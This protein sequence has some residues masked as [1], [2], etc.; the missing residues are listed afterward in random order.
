[1]ETDFLLLSRQQQLHL[2]LG[3]PIT[4]ADAR[5]VER[6]EAAVGTTWITQARRL[7]DVFLRSDECFVPT[8]QTGTLTLEAVG[9]ASKVCITHHARHSPSGLLQ[10]LRLS[11][12]AALHKLARAVE[13]KP[14]LC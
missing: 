1:M 4:L 6:I 8:A 12:A 3:H 10:A 5:A 14:S 11:L 13:P 9:S 7:E 2:Q